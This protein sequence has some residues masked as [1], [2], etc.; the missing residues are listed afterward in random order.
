MKH[1][2]PMTLQQLVSYDSSEPIT[3][4]DEIEALMKLVAAMPAR[5]MFRKGLQLNKTPV[6]SLLLRT[7]ANAGVPG[8]ITDASGKDAG[9]A[10]LPIEASLTYAGLTALVKYGFEL[11]MANHNARLADDILYD[12]ALLHMQQLDPPHGHQLV[13]QLFLMFEAGTFLRWAADRNY[14]AGLCNCEY[15]ITKTEK[16]LSLLYAPGAEKFPI[17][18]ILRGICEVFIEYGTESYYEPPEGVDI[19]D[20]ERIQELESARELVLTILIDTFAYLRAEQ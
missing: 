1:Q 9:Q 6:L 2:Y 5:Q 16:N 10:P 3:A 14:A 7:L 4:P 18:R 17:G 13:K 19:S 12:F 20:P 11:A 8:V 15:R